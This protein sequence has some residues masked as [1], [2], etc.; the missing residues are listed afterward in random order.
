[1]ETIL[2]ILYLIF[3]VSLYYGIKVTI[4]GLSKPFDVTRYREYVRKNS[5]PIK[6]NLPTTTVIKHRYLSLKGKRS[7]KM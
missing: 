3:I 4:D 1:M 7:Q 5:K 6:L 2:L